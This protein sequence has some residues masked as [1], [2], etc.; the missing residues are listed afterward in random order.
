MFVMTWDA[1]E[2]WNI[3]SARHFFI[4]RVD[5]VNTQRRH[6]MGFRKVRKGGVL[7]VITFAAVLFSVA[8][9][10]C[11]DIIA[12]REPDIEY[13]DERD[14]VIRGVYKVMEPEMEL[15]IRQDYLEK[16]VNSG[17]F[18]GLTLDDIRVRRYYGTFR[19]RVV[20]MMDAEGREL[21]PE[22]R[23]VVLGVLCRMVS[24]RT[25]VRFEDGD[26]ILVWNNGQFYDIEDAWAVWENG[27]RWLRI[28]SCPIP[29][30]PWV[31]LRLLDVWELNRI[32]NEHHGLDI[33][34]ETRI[35]ED[36]VNNWRGGFTGS[37]FF[38]YLG[39]YNDSIVIR[40][41]NE[42]TP[43]RMRTIFVDGLHFRSGAAGDFIFTWRWQ[44]GR[45][46]Y[47]HEA[48]ALGYLSSQDIRE[49]WYLDSAPPMHFF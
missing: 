34:T 27:T 25:R 6:D 44:D 20:V 29:S 9:L 28:A 24:T 1:Q 32:F 17:E 40:S 19:N 46:L 5:C 42:L 14:P 36:F 41:V 18:P 7:A 10:G 33:K 23:E 38:R 8:V 4:K 37:L 11:A 22:L 43:I 49:I 2:R 15:R 45:I 3:F 31:G 16:L 26:G 35:R 12:D 13:P 30:P 47:L 48:F 39:T 21:S